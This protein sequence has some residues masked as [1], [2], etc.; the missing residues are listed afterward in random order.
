MEV[1]RLSRE[2]YAAT[3]SGKGAAIRGERWNS[4]GVEMIYNSPYAIWKIFR[5]RLF[6][7]TKLREESSQ[8]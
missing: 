8:L 2:K 5:L 4:V 6:S 1:F 7:A 3:L